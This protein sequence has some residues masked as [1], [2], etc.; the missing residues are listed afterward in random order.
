MN[1]PAGSRSS[2]KTGAKA[3]RRIY[4]EAWNGD[5]SYTFDRIGRGTVHIAG[6]CLS[7][8]GSIQPG[9]LQQYVYDA[10]EGGAG[11]DGLLQRFQLLVWPDPP[12]AWVNV[13]RWPYKQERERAYK[14][15]QALAR[16]EPTALGA[17]GT[18]YNPLPALRFTPDAQALFDA[19]RSELEHRL[20]S[21]TIE[22]PAFESH[23][24]ITVTHAELSTAVPSHE[25]LRGALQR[26]GVTGCDQNGGGVV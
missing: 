13:D 22:T 24:A 19:W 21:G 15:F 2:V 20:R 14:V 10:T 18:D 5:G 3:I 23:L 26:W 6:L 12:K 7:L 1:S 17:T 9:K 4:L 25:R 11:D 16:L 8:C